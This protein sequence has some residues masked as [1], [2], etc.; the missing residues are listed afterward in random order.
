M[1]T[2]FALADQRIFLWLNKLSGQSL[3]FDTTIKLVASD[4]LV[5]ASLGLCLIALWF[6]EQDRQ[7]HQ[8]QQLGVIVALTAM[9][10]SNLAVMIINAIYARPR[11][12]VDLDIVPLLYTPTDPS[13]PANSTAA[14]FGVSVSIWGVHR[15]LGAI[16]IGVSMIFGISRICGG[17]H[18]PTDVIFGALIGATMS[19]SAFKLRDLLMPV[20]TRFLRV[21][22][23]F[24]LA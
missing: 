22:R 19:Y 2:T 10:I 1:A 16:C 12:F 23:M 13:F 24:C 18:Y 8:V 4:Y 3:V 7:R 11:P 9:S 20:L 6:V 17:V 14:A 21:A 15:K 5:P